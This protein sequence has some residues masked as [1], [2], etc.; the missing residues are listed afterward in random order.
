MR[1]ENFANEVIKVDLHNNFEVIGMAKWDKVNHVYLVSLYMQREDLDSLRLL[2][3]YE[4]ITFKSA[5]NAIKFEILKYIE[6]LNEDHTFEIYQEK[7]NF[8]DRCFNIGLDTLE[9]K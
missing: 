8:E 4:N 2:G 6:K 3:K 1:Y 9:V 5:R 7:I